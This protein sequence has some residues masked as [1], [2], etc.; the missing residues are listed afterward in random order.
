MKRTL[1]AGLSMLLLSAGTTTA[2]YAETM[3]AQELSMRQSMMANPILEAALTPNDLA[4]LAY[5]GYLRD[6]GISS[7][8]QLIFDY[9]SGRI[10][11]KDIVQAA[12]NANRLPASLLNDQSYL[13][14]VNLQLSGLDIH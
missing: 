13:S 4:N 12:V 3:T 11:G 1:I 2:A 6:Q 10:Q 7:Y 8:S 9:E 5:Q 14:A